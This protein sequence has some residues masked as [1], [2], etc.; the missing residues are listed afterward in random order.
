MATKGKCPQCSKTV[1]STEVIT[2]GPPNKEQH[3]HNT[4][5][6]CQQ[7]G[8]TWKLTVGSYKY[9]DGKVTFLLLF[10]SFSFFSFFFCFKTKMKWSENKKQIC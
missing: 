8:C 5:F 4:C 2:V 1:Y 6:K 3:F 7:P 9:S 10:F